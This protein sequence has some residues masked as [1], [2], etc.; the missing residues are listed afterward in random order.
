MTGHA[1][2]RSFLVEPGYICLP[3]EPKRLA[4]VAA[5]GIALTLFDIRLKR[6]GMTH[7]AYPVRRDGLSTAMFACPAIVGL[8]RM[9][10]DSGSHA[11]DMEARLFG[12][13]ENPDAPGYMPGLGADNIRVA[14]E[15]LA[16]FNFRIAGEDTGGCRGRKIVFHSGTGEVLVAAVDRIRAADWYPDCP[17]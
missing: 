5:S 11:G 14:R 6:G 12:A 3:G 10:L 4:A 9:F 13:A 2:T 17:R 16:R 8:S 1:I 7:F 15:L